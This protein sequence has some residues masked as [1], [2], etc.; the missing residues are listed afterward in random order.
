[1]AA[2]HAVADDV[3]PGDAEV[4]E[5]RGGILGEALVGDGAIDVGRAA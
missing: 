5:E 3:G 2:P 4:G 1:L